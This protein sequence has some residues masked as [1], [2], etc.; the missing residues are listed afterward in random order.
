M[1]KLEFSYSVGGNVHIMVQQI[2]KQLQSLKKFNIYLPYGLIILPVAI[3]PR[4]K[5]LYTNAHSRFICDREKRE[6][7]PMSINS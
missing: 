6:T 1:V 3:Y 5:D 7:T 2:W 4:N